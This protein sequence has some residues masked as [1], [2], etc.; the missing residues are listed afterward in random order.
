MVARLEEY[1]SPYNEILS[2]LTKGEVSYDK[3]IMSRSYVS[4]SLEFSPSYEWKRLLP[5]H[6]AIPAGLETRLPIGTL[7]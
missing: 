2:L 7:H 4:R 1:Y 3:T 5:W 6:H